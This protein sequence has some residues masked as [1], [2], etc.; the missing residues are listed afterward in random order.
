MGSSNNLTEL[1][2]DIKHLN[3][4]LKEYVVNLQK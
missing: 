4:S 3:A 2:F 1:K